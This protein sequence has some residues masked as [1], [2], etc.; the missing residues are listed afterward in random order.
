MTP[1]QAVHNWVNRVKTKQ[2]LLDNFPICPYAK[3][4]P[5]VIEVDKLTE[6]AIL[7]VI[8]LTVYVEKTVNSTFEEV[9]AICKKLNNTYT[10]HIFLPD[11]PEQKNYIQGIETGN[12]HFP[13]I[14]AQL[15]SELLPARRKLE[16]TKY[17]LFWD[18][19]YLSEIKSYGD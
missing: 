19:E 10:D 16:N 5:K 7:N 18:K 17:Y 2:E 6:S 11:H 9:D 15:K 13:L 4:M 1:T 8:E 14:I 12:Q 3:E